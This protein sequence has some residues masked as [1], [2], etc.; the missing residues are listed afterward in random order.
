MNSHWFFSG[1]E[2]LFTGPFWVAVAGIGL[3]VVLAVLA[4]FVVMYVFQSLSLYTIA[5]RRGIQNPGLAWVPVA[6]AW[7][8]G[9]ISDQYQYVTRG[10]VRN[11]RKL[12][13]GLTIAAFFFG[14]AGTLFL[15]SYSNLLDIFRGDGPLLAEGAMGATIAGLLTAVL[16][17]FQYIS[18]Y[19][20]YQSCNPGSSVVFLVL[21]I[22]LPVTAPFFLFASRNKELGMPSRREQTPPQDQQPPKPQSSQEPWEKRDRDHPV[23]W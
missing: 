8:L 22:V 14:G 1:W 17:V 4:L 15:V 9:S 5:K 3:L 10:K 13:L 20:V 19:D 12:L 6:Y 23:E 7:I 21:S 16:A 11:S 18:L 2:E